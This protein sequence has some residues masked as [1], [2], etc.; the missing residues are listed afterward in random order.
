MV[1]LIVI[2]A[3]K[4]RTRDT[5]LSLALHT[6]SPM[7]SKISTYLESSFGST[8]K[9]LNFFKF[10]GWT[11]VLGITLPALS[12]VIISS[13]VAWVVI[14][15]FVLGIIW[16]FLVQK[17]GVVLV[18]SPIDAGMVSVFFAVFVTTYFSIDPSRGMRTV[19]IWSALILLFYIVLALFRYGISFYPFVKAL[20]LVTSAFVFFGYFEVFIWL[21]N[22]YGK[23][24]WP[25][26]LPPPIIRASGLV[27]NPNPFGDLLGMVFAMAVI[28]FVE[29]K[30]YKS[31]QWWFWLI[32]TMGMLIVSQS[33]GTWMGLFVAFSFYGL[34][35]TWF[36][37]R[38][39]GR[40]S[41]RIWI[42]TFLMVVG[43]SII[44]VTL[45]LVMRPISSTIP[46][47]FLIRWELWR[48]AL[49]SWVQ[50]PWLGNGPNT[51]ATL[52]LQA[53]PLF[54]QS[55]HRAAHNF[56]LNTLAEMGILGIMATLLLFIQIIWMLWQ[57]KRWNQ[58]MFVFVT[59]LIVFAVH[60]QVDLTWL[61]TMMLAA[62]FLAG[63]VAA[64]PYQDISRHHISI[65]PFFVCVWLFIIVGGIIGWK[66]TK[67]Y[68]QG[69]DKIVHGD[70]KEASDDFHLGQSFT[71]Y[72]NSLFLYAAGFSDGVLAFEDET[73]LK[74][75]IQTQEKIVVLEPGWSVHYA[76]L[77]GLY[78]QANR[79]EEAI[80]AM[81]KA[82]A[83]A[84]EAPLYYLNLG[85]W[86]EEDGD[87]ETAVSIYNQLYNLPYTWQTSPFWLASPV[88]QS[89]A[90]EQSLQPVEGYDLLFNGREDEAIFVFQEMLGE[91]ESASSY[92]GVGIAY[93]YKNNVESATDAFEQ[94]SILATG[95]TKDIIILWQAVL[96]TAQEE[97]FYVTI[98]EL[99][100][101]YS[102]SDSKK[103][104][105]Y[106]TLPVFK[107]EP[108]LHDLLPQLSCFTFSSTVGS[109]MQLLK[110]WYMLQ[111]DMENVD[112]IETMLRGEGDG[113]TPCTPLLDI[114]NEGM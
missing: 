46:P 54:D 25:L 40:F 89:V 110:E 36:D 106:Y 16:L 94:A 65:V 59:P 6:T 33:R 52:Q 81:Q 99:Q 98:E 96:P 77:A 61:R 58:W 19:W 44:L 4:R 109:H 62:I 11:I 45:A 48:I 3:K 86:Y 68:E 113:L 37:S 32:A 88:T 72:P 101:H 47:S 14:L 26:I 35:K 95:T 103:F 2:I 91:R 66:N 43:G 38:V 87:I 69:V 42:N 18:S 50:N 90:A 57:Q 21:F 107:R 20:M 71:P 74:A 75:A 82:I 70:W 15:L 30:R 105:S 23:R 104:T 1:L 108:I 34:S 7:F 55:L 97:D 67:Q 79:K 64:F 111:G 100:Y 22:W 76:N 53:T 112:Y 63:L 31:V 24:G 84:P 102:V 39:S 56:Y 49:E 114:P 17:K 80:V 78:R 60:M 27:D 41:L 51:Y 12:T 85:L 73:Y 13:V 9:G 29:F 92:L 10:A 28:V 83:H 93:L 8:A 5:F